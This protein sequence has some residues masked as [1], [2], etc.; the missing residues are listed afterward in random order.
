M[1]CP[2]LIIAKYYFFVRQNRSVWFIIMGFDW[3][4]ILTFCVHFGV[5]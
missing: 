5:L 4:G 2:K 1:K 3:A